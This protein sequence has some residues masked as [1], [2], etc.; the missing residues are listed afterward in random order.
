MGLFDFL[1]PPK[2][3]EP[4]KPDDF[5][6]EQREFYRGIAATGDPLRDRRDESA[7]DRMLTNASVMDVDGPS[8]G[9]AVANRNRQNVDTQRTIAQ[10]LG[11]SDQV[12]EQR[13]LGAED[14]LFQ[15]Q[16]Q[17][18][19]DLDE[20]EQLMASHQA[21]EEIA[22][23]NWQSGL[24]RAGANLLGT[25]VGAPGVG[26]MLFNS[27]EQA[28]ETVT[29]RVGMFAGNP[30]NWF[31]DPL[32]GSTNLW[33]YNNLPPVPPANNVRGGLNRVY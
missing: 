12:E 18:K 13:I 1:K 21:A 8:A 10:F 27:T 26:S 25:V 31:D 3:P 32:M 14:K 15:L 20:Y 24:F 23:K 22:R 16:S 19:M 4:V 11:E 29:S 30:A 9:F 5:T 17:R 2:I 33:G 28:P 6:A 7:I